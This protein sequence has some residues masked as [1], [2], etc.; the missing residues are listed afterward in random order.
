MRAF[1]RRL[2]G[3]GEISRTVE[4]FVWHGPCTIRIT[5]D[6]SPWGV[7]AILEINGQLTAWIADEFCDLD[8]SRLGI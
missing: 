2:I 1:L 4:A 7:G 5:C 6:A 3:C 8:R